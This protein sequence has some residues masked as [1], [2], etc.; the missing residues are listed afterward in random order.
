M[1]F[2]PLTYRARIKA[3][4]WVAQVGIMQNSVSTV[5]IPYDLA[6]QTKLTSP[7]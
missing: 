3:L 6:R 5:R 7:S 4:Y 1:E 2:V